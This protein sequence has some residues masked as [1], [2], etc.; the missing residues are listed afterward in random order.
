MFHTLI[1]PLCNFIDFKATR[2]SKFPIDLSVLPPRPNYHVRASLFLLL[3]TTP[4]SL[5]KFINLFCPF[6]S[7][8]AFIIT[9]SFEESQLLRLWGSLIRGCNTSNRVSS[10]TMTSR[11][12]FVFL[13]KIA[14]EPTIEA[15]LVGL[16]NCVLATVPSFS[17]IVAL[18][19]SIKPLLS[20]I[21]SCS[22][23]LPPSFG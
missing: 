4:P 20:G 5:F 7:E 15:F 12:L 19:C 17:N 2:T 9:S 10:Y 21:C 22:I 13:Q 1:I 14:T 8:R 16:L 11:A 6:L 18:N 3:D 23:F